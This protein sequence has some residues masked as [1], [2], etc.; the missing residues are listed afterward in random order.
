VS[1]ENNFS[2]SLWYSAVNARSWAVNQRDR[3]L[4][5]H[6]TSFFTRLMAGGFNPNAHIDVLKEHKLI[7]VAVPKCASTT[8]RT[9]LSR[10]TGAAPTTREHSHR[11]R[12][13]GLKSPRLVGM[14]AFYR[15]ATSPDS[16]RFSIVRNP[17]ARLV[18]AWAD[19]YR[20][21][22]LVPGDSFVDQYLEHRAKIDGGLP[23]GHSATLDFTN[24]VTFAC[25]TAESRVN[26]HW[27]AQ[28]DLIAMP[29]IKLDVIGKVESFDADFAEVLAHLGV[30]RELSRDGGMHLNATRH[31]PWP[32]YYTS[33][34]ANRVYRAYERDFDRLGY[35]RALTA[36]P[37]AAAAMN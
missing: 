17:Y 6:A 7:Y 4:D 29:G 14:S 34:L 24:F 37:M 22:P 11:R 27:H 19:K 13:S 2:Q 31:Q 25:A 16:L 21:K 10:L 18:S 8:V 30:E 33:A 5:P 36:P 32:D 28:D 23:H 35:A 3:L 1:R 15:L 12:A 26:A 20:G 9:V